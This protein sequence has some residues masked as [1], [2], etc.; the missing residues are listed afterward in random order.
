MRHTGGWAGVRR[1]AT[2]AGLLWAGLA[3]AATTVIPGAGPP[4]IGLRA[5]AAE[6]MRQ[7]PGSVIEVPPSVGI[8]GA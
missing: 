6:F 8:A 2:L 7:R 5:L 3:G 4:E 1:T